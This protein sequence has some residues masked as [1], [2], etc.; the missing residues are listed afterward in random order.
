LRAAAEREIVMRTGRNRTWRV[1]TLGLAIL[2]LPV[3]ATGTDP[4]R[5]FQTEAFSETTDLR[6]V[7]DAVKVRLTQFAGERIANS[8]EP[9]W[10][11]DAVI[12]GDS[13]RPFR[14]LIRAGIAKDLTFVEYQ[15]GGQAPDQHFVLFQTAGA[16]ATLIKACR[17]YLPT[18]LW[19]LKKVVGTPACR[20]RSKEH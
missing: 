10:A 3:V 2:G 16:R 4:L 1:W 15:H 14:R 11:T 8:D 12:L 18:E 17:G 13:A 5:R 19:R 20:W 7:S 6:A 9:F